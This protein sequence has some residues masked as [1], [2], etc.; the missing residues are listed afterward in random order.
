L[1]EEGADLFS[2]IFYFTTSRINPRLIGTRA[3]RAF[4]LLRSLFKTPV[5]LDLARLT[6]STSFPRT[7][8]LAGQHE[9]SIE[10]IFVAISKDF[11]VLIHSV[12]FAR[13]SISR[14]KSGGIRVIVPD[15]EVEECKDLFFKHGLQDVLVVPEGSMISTNSLQ[16]LRKYFP[17][18]ANWVLQ[19]ILKVQAVLT[20]NSDASLIV[21][22]DTLLLTRRSWFSSNGSQLLTPSYEFNAPYYAF[23]EKLGVCS[24]HPNFTFISHHMLMQKSELRR[25]FD[26][27]NWSGVDELV[28]YICEN[29]DLDLDSPV[30]VEYE[31]YSQALLSRDR[32]KVH[33]SLWSNISIP[34]KYLRTLLKSKLLLFVLG[35]SFHSVSLHSWSE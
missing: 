22:S 33:L 7:D 31:L 24:S 25:T 9:K 13:N 3:L 18:R 19:Q 30:C 2:N 35:K 20:S 6:R 26:Q 11:P 5:E 16:L 10:L 23:L 17:K 29:A 8:V 15:R 21:D 28:T 4:L 12:R 32:S 14:Y 1:N 27:M 34:R